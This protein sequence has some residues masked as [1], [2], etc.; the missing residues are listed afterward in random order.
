MFV[1]WNS[2][3]KPDFGKTKPAWSCRDLNTIFIPVSGK[4]QTI[5]PIWFNPMETNF[6][7][8][9]C[10]N[11]AW[12]FNEKTLLDLNGQRSQLYRFKPSCECCLWTVKLPAK[13][14]SS[15]MEFLFWW[16]KIIG[17]YRTSRPIKKSGKLSKSGL[18]GN[19]TFCS[20]NAGLFKLLKT[21]IKNKFFCLLTYLKRSFNLMNFNEILLSG[22]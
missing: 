10:F 17:L 1:K 9:S 21:K 16:V 11:T 15:V 5:V 18:F 7:F 22:M 2:G 14:I 20:L 8:K 4:N 6:T 12:F 13:I 19:R 3:K